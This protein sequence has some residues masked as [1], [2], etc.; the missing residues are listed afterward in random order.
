[1]YAVLRP[2]DSPAD[3]GPDGLYVTD[4]GGHAFAAYAAPAG[5]SVLVRPDGYLRWGCDLTAP[6]TR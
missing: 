3:G 4:D 2:G 5:S 1:V 6:R